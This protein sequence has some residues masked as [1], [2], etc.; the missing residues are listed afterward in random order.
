MAFPDSTTEQEHTVRLQDK[1][2]IVVGAGQTPGDTVGN[3]RA[4]AVR[5]AQEGARV[6]CVDRDL[7][8][9]QATV[10]EI[11]RAGGIGVAY[12]ADVVAEA[13]CASMIDETVSAFGR[14]DILH[15][16]VGIG[17]HDTG[18]SDMTEEIWDSILDTNLKGVVWATKHTLPVM[19]RQ[20]SGSII[21]ISSVAAVCAVGLAAYKASKAALNAYT[22]TVAMGNARYGIRANVIMPGLMNTP[23]A[24]EGFVASGRDRE[25]L[26]AQRNAAVPLKGGMGSAT[27]IAN[28]ALFLASDEAAFITGVNLPV[29]GGQSAKIG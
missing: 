20:G 25:E 19:R 5:F 23:M 21:N 16:N 12:A 29:D 18:P 24:I 27:D 22:H 6:M 28:A 17:T 26:I 9:A 10:E 1:A 15:N 8:R 14:I 3:G 13:A 7:D 4:C 2:A 11:E